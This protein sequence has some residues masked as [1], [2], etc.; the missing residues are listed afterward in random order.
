MTT[1]ET[2]S[3]V[4]KLIG[5][6]FLIRSLFYLPITISS[7]FG[8]GWQDR[9]EWIGTLLFAMFLSAIP[10]LL[11]LCIII[12]SEAIA[13]RLIKNNEPVD[14]PG[15]FLKEDVMVV[16]FSCVGL[17]LIV[18]GIPDFIQIFSNLLIFNRYNSD[19]M[20]YPYRCFYQ[21]SRLIA[22]VVQIG[23]GVWLFVGSKGL[24]K[25]WHKIRS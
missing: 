16:V 15:P 19:A 25:L 14:V 20:S 24:V 23:L 18:T 2:G 13:G 12:F 17:Y 11:S 6:F 4:L 1:R 10:L 5:I 21:L 8:V 7:L 22:P 3:L 9:G